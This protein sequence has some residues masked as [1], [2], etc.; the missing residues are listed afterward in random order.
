[1]VDACIKKETIKN[2][3]FQP[4][5]HEDY[6]FWQEIVNKILDDNIYIDNQPNSIYIVNNK[7]LSSSK[8]SVIF[9]IWRIYKKTNKSILLNFLKIFIRGLLQILVKLKEVPIKNNK[10][11]QDFKFYK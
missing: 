2:T 8:I 4:I 7:S 6:L 5:Y 10:K 9:W 3:R 1:M 11:T